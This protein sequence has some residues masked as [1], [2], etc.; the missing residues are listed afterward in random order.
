MTP[1]DLGQIGG[2]GPAKAHR[3]GTKPTSAAA[4][5]SIKPS[6][7]ESQQRV[8]DRL[9][10]RA[11]TDHELSESLQMNPSTL[12]PRRGELL[13]MGLIRDSGETRQTGS[14]RAAIV[15]EVV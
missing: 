8:L 2:T 3:G 6:I 1:I 10:E 5:D 7:T 13:A 12:R 9:K 15:W 11:L 14:G 4:Y